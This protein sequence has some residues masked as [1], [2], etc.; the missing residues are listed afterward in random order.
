[1]QISIKPICDWPIYLTASA[2]E[3]QACIMQTSFHSTTSF[4]NPF[5]A[6]V[7]QNR[8]TAHSLLTVHTQQGHLPFSST[9]SFILQLN[10]TFIFPILIFK[11]FASN[12]DFHFTILHVDFP[13]S[14]PS[15]SSHLCAVIPEACSRIDLTSKCSVKKLIFLG[16]FYAF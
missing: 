3:R 2:D 4:M 16:Q 12:P 15:R 5:L 1:M 11:P 14:L 9:L 6:T 8:I 7:A 10:I 13:R